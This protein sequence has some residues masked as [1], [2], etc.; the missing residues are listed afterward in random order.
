MLWTREDLKNRAK[1]MLKKCHWTAVAVCL[2]AGLFAGGASSGY[3][4]SNIGQEYGNAGYYGG[5][6]YMNS[7]ILL[8]I[9]GGVFLLV[10]IS[11]LLSIFLGH[12]LTV[13]KYH[14]FLRNRESIGKFEM[15]GYAF[16]SGRYL[17][18]IGVMFVMA[19]K[20]SLWSLLFVVPGIIKSYEYRMVPYI[21]AENPNIEMKR[22]FELSRNM[23]MGQKMDTF[24]LDLSFIPWTLLGVFTCGIALVFYV[25]PYIEATDA[26][27]Y[28]VLRW[29]AMNRGITNSLELPGFNYQ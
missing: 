11:A 5:Y 29:D 8:I 1:V 18:I 21:M 9:L 4:A 7:Q 25:S 19:L 20:I 3:S 14:F 2:V 27:L 10:L 22:A 15:L 12:A 13:G 6:G 17:H 28:S 23:M 16:K 26:E 24:V